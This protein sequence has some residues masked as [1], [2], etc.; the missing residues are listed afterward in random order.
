MFL[1]VF[2]LIGIYSEIWIHAGISTGI[3]TPRN[4]PGIHAGIPTGIPTPR[5]TLGIHAGIPTGIPSL[6]VNLLVF[7]LCR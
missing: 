6:Q 2:L 7:L 1:L 4:I 5:N 3:P